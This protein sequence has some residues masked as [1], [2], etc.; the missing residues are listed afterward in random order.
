MRSF[1]QPIQI[2]C[3]EVSMIRIAMRRL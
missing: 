1:P 2:G 3:S